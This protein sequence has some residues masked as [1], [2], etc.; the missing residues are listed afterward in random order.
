M[1]TRM[2]ILACAAILCLGSLVA[3]QEGDRGIAVVTKPA[4]A[5]AERGEF[6][7]FV[8]GIN[9]Y[10]NFPKLATAVGD[11][12][13]VKAA[14]MVR[15]GFQPKNVVE[16]YDLD[17]TAKRVLVQLRDLARKIGPNDSLLIYY[18]GHGQI[19]EITQAGAWVPV[20]GAPDE[21]TTWIDNDVLKKHLSL[22]AIKA[23]HVLLVSDSCFAGDFFSRSASAPAITEA[24]VKTAFGKTS[25][26]ALTSGGVEPVTDA[27]FG[28]H[29]VFAHF[30][31]KA[32]TENTDPY[33]LPSAIFERVKGG[34]SQNAAQQAQHGYLAGTGGEQGGAFVL[35]LEAAT[36]SMDDMIKEKQARATLLEQA[37]T[38]ARAKN[39]AEAEEIKKREAELAA[40]DARIAELQ[41]HLGTAGGGDAGTLDQLVAIVEQQEAQAQEIEDL[42]AQ[43]QADRQAREAEIERLK[44]AEIGKRQAVIDADIAKYM[45]VAQSQFGQNLK[46]KAWDALLAKWGLAKGSVAE[47]D[48]DG[49]CRGLKA[50]LPLPAVPEGMVLVEG[51]SFQMGSDADQ[52][53]E[54]PA[55]TVTVGSF[56]VGQTEVAVWNFRQFIDATG[57]QTSAE[58]TGGAM[59]MTPEGTAELKSDAGWNNPYFTQDENQPAVCISWH[60]AVAYANWLGEAEGLTKCYDTTGPVV[61]CD[62]DA[63]GY[64]LPT[65]AEWEFAARG[66]N[67]T[68][69]FVFSGGNSVGEVAWYADNSEK[70]TH[71]VAE[72]GSN[73]LNL[74]DMSGNAWEWCWDWY[75]GTW[76]AQSTQDNPRGPEAG[77]YRVLRGSAWDGAADGMRVAF[78]GCGG[79]T[80]AHYGI[81]F[82]LVRTVKRVMPEEAA[83]APAGK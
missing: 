83:P 25:R 24:F 33:L 77:E 59:V 57:Y 23:R 12:R 22:N 64:R 48:V 67:W 4:L 35:F 72:L 66:G 42:R 76:Y 52:E 11:A 9:D 51:G 68:Q 43:A 32:L 75:D 2:T 17:A 61:A 34:I 74:F 20:D 30:F 27:G 26:E 60:D 62:F 63:D 3:G 31:I 8:I 81:G 65:E 49:L 41:K 54:K 5:A 28:G 13:A 29:S 36:G 15:Y 21:P 78:R 6:H 55:H 71:L 80:G 73:E 50:Y 82:R 58:T 38:A 69:G 7:L 46:I 70:R 47:G 18:A 79:D 40:L 14:L 44:A 1:P 45:K 10:I 53:D 56:L 37:E 39:A 19:D 16:L